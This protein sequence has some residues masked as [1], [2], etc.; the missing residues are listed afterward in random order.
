MKKTLLAAAM[1]ILMVGSADAQDRYATLFVGGKSL[2]E[3][4]FDALNSISGTFRFGGDFSSDNGYNLGAIIGRR[5]APNIR[6]E[7][8]FS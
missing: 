1:S 3:T 5:F 7:I 6:G 2:D 8:E 4:E